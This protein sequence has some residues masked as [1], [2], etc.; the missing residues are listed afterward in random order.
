MK[1]GGIEYLVSFLL[2]LLGFIFGSLTPKFGFFAVGV[3]DVFQ[4]LSAIGTVM[5]AVVAIPALNSWRKQFKHGEKIRRLESLRSIDGAFAALYSLCDS[6]HQ[7]VICKLRRD[8]GAAAEA[9][10]SNARSVYFERLAEYS[11]CWRDARIVMSPREVEAF[12]WDPEKLSGLDRK[13]VMAI[14]MIEHQPRR[15]EADKS[16]FL[17]LMDEYIISRVALNGAV[18]EAR[19]DIDDLIRANI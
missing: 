10:V 18:N 9:E 5:A 12:R 19:E 7:Y 6:C 13:L 17:T 3:S 16:P 2:L 1:I 11:K 15:G 8:D 4:I 14:S